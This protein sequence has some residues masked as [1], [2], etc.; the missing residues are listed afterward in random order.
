MLKLCNFP[1][2]ETQNNLSYKTAGPLVSCIFN[3]V[4][5]A[6]GSL[7]KKW[8]P[9]ERGGFLTAPHSTICCSK[10]LPS[11]SKTGLNPQL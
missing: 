3:W 8:V 9:G 11:G 2:N 4:F 7:S 6:L 5:I 10:A 1:G